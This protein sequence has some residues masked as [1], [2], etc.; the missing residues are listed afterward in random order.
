MKILHIHD[1]GPQALQVNALLRSMVVAIDN[2]SSTNEAAEVLATNSYDLAI[3]DADALDPDAANELAAIRAFAPGMQVLVCGSNDSLQ[4][5]TAAI[6]NGAHD[7]VLRPVHPDEL[8][9]RIFQVTKR[10]PIGNMDHGA[11]ATSFGPLQINVH[12]GNASLDGNPL[13]LTPRE[14]SVLQVLVRAKGNLVSKERIASR[15]FTLDEESDPKSIETYIHRLRKKTKHP[16]LTIE[17]V[18]GLGYRLVETCPG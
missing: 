10:L 5:V 6:E 15:V 9:L 18:R 14:R 17:T 3:W 16:L 11:T 1:A 2:A 13:V 12:Q 7:F 4:S 8:R